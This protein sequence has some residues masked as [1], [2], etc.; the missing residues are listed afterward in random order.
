MV[1]PLVKEVWNGH[2]TISVRMRPNGKLL[3]S[4][5]V[6]PDSA[7][8]PVRRAIQSLIDALSTADRDELVKM[9]QEMD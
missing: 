5:V 4:A 9:A 2:A 6:D 7:A 1:Q 3:I 8:P